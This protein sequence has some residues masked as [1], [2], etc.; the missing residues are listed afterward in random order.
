MEQTIRFYCENIKTGKVW[1]DQTEAHHLV[2]VLR[3]GIGE[4]VELFDGKGVLAKAI[5]ADVK[6]KNV[7]LE[8][9]NIQ[10]YSKRTS[11][12]IV[13][14]ASVAKGHRFDQLITKCTELGTDHI[15]AV[16]FE[17]TVKQS[18][19]S[20]VVQRYNKLA[21]SAAKQCGRIILP[22]IT[23]PAGLAEI[24][25]LLKNTYTNAK[26]IYGSLSI[27]AKSIT[28]LINDRSDIIAFVGPEGGITC[29]EE[30]LLKQYNAGKVKITNTVLRIET[31]AIAFASI[32]CADRD[33]AT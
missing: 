20:S 5:I 2:N 28:E 24:L 27:D 30:N 19:G 12:R 32:L 21:I 25:E 6:Q 18:K 31:A 22:S 3:L 11:G 29:D 4:P 10:N 14:A 9:D 26:L 17:R 13:I 33:R 7:M 23:E 1:L 15:A 16:L 8:V